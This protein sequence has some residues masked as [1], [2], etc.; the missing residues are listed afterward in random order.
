MEIVIGIV[1][2]AAVGVLISWA[3]PNPSPGHLDDRDQR[4]P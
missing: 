4:H 2:F 1:L 3:F